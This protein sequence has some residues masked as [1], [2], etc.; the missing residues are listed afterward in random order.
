MSQ[1][2]H[3]ETIGGSNS[4]S[5][6]HIIQTILKQVAPLCKQGIVALLRR[7]HLNPRVGSEVE[8]RIECFVS[9]W[10]AGSVPLSAAQ[11]LNCG[12]TPF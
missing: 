10:G 8:A 5:H 9:W 2:S 1:R 3:K 11:P 6:L 7:P 4:R 12:S